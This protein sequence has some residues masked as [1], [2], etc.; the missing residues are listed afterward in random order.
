MTWLTPN[1]QSNAPLFG[2]ANVTLPAPGVSGGAAI[3]ACGMGFGSAPRSYSLTSSGGTTWTTVWADIL[4]RVYQGVHGGGVPNTYVVMAHNLGLNSTD[5]AGNATFSAQTYN[6]GSST[7]AAAAYTT[8]HTAGSVFTP[9]ISLDT[10][11]DGV[12]DGGAG[13][14]YSTLTWAP[15]V[16]DYS[17]GGA[18]HVWGVYAVGGF[19][20]TTNAN[21]SGHNMSDGSVSVTVTPGGTAFGVMLWMYVPVSENYGMNEP[22]GIGEGAYQNL[23]ASGSTIRPQPVGQPFSK[24]DEPPGIG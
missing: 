7:N 12:S 18:Y 14:P 8:G 20:S 4:G 24:L 6:S 23:A 15:P 10:S 16:A 1:F 22:P 5:L 19:S 2:S 17:R 3:I 9:T 13:G 11:Q 21:T